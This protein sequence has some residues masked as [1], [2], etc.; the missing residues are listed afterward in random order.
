MCVCARMCYLGK[1]VAAFVLVK[2]RHG[3]LGWWTVQPLGSAFHGVFWCP[4]LCDEQGQEH[5]E[6]LRIVLE[7]LLRGI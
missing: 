6:L 4:S 5:Q 3:R 1:F 7:K 2:R